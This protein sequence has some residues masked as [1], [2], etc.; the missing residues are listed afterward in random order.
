MKLE[1]VDV[2]RT[3][4]AQTHLDM[5][6]LSIE[7][8]ALNVLLGRTL[9]GKT[10]LMRVLA[11][12]D[13]PSSGRL[14]L[15]GD[16]ITGVPVQK[17][18]VSMV[19]QQFINYPH[20]TV[21]ENI[22]SPLKVAGQSESTIKAKVGEVAELLHISEFLDK[23]PLAL[24]GGQQQRTSMAR[25][26]VKDASLILFDEPL[27]NLDYKLREELRTELRTLFLERETI[28]V[29]STTEPYEALALG[30]HTVLLHEGRLIQTGA[31]MDVYKQPVDLIAADLLTEPAINVLQRSEH[32]FEG[33]DQLGIRPEHIR[34]E[35]GDASDLR[36]RVIVDVAE[37]SGSETFLHTKKQR[38]D[39][40]KERIEH[41]DVIVRLPGIHQYQT[42]DSIDLFMP[43][44]KLFQFDLEGRTIHQDNDPSLTR[45]RSIDV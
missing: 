11:G 25:A 40:K 38:V 33:V 19:Y 9:S 42:G 14:I 12:L 8:G 31:I 43:Q 6:S 45:T 5:V 44:V 39:S 36:L 35:Q 32:D 2:C 34:L 7:S 22:A 30:G 16:D 13:K 28:V 27:V 4:N 24:S 26:L 1:L 18:N 10:S 17:R 23:Y 37:I 3:V 20:L 15:D 41:D 21:F 29:Y